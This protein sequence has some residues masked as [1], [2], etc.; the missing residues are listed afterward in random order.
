[1]TRGSL[2]DENEIYSRL[3]ELWHPDM[4]FRNYGIGGYGQAHSIR[5]YRREG[6]ATGPSAGNPPIFIEHG[7]SMITLSGPHSTVIGQ[8]RR[9]ARCGSSEGFREAVARVHLFFWNHSKIYA[10]FYN[11]GIRPY[12]SNWDARRD[13]DGALEVTRRLLAKLARDARSH[14]ADL[15]ILILPS[16]AEMAGR[17]NGMEPERARVM[18]RNFVA[19]TAGVF[20]LDT[21]PVLAAEDPDRTYGV[22]D[23]HLTPYGN[24]LVAQALDRWLVQ[25]WPVGPKGVAPMRSFH[26]NPPVIPDCSRADSYVRHVKSPQSQ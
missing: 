25:E 15:L 17:D 24:F 9:Q 2:V 8:D 11:V 16:W 19:D 13:I 26:A 21:T 6:A 7:L 23:K 18:L 4:S 5:V 10:W 22:I 12:F 14:R 20:L 3:V 1:M